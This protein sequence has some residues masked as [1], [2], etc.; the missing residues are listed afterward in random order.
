M[1][2]ANVPVTLKGIFCDVLKP[3]HG[4]DCTANGITSRY[5]QVLL[6]GDGVPQAFEARPDTPIV[7][8]VR[9]DIGDRV[10]CHVEPIEKPEG[11]WNGPMAG[12]NFIYSCDS[13]FHAVSH[14]PL[15]VHDR[16]EK[17]NR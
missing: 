15:S 2:D 4:T 1:A 9:R 16:F 13:R 10:Y 6:I 8:L 17:W 5:T 7:R 12:G 3:C 11:S 14:Y